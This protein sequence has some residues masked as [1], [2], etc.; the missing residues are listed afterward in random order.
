MRIMVTS[1]LESIMGIFNLLIIV[2]CVFLMFSIL[3]MNLLQDKL[4]FCNLNGTQ[5]TTG[6][7]GPYGVDQASCIAQGGVW[8][9]QLVNF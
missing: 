2:L 8:T 4:N 9:T 1:L 6:N 3:A 5:L 7:Y